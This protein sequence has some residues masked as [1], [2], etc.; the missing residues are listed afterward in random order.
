MTNKAKVKLIDNA[1]KYTA[2]KYSNIW[3]GKHPE[4]K[5]YNHLNDHQKQ[6]LQEILSKFFEV[7]ETQNDLPP[8]IRTTNYLVRRKENYVYKQEIEIK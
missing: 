4:S 5:H 8:P 7:Y 1:A 3:R 6:G 2:I